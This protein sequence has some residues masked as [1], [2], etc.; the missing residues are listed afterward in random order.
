[1]AERRRHAAVMP[2]RIPNTVESTV[3]TP[4]SATVAPALLQISSITGAFV[5]YERP[6]LRVAVCLMYAQNWSSVEPSR[7]NS[8]RS[9]AFCAS[10]RLRPRNSVP[11]GSLERT[12]NRK[13]LNTTTK[14]RVASDPSPCLSTNRR[15]HSRSSAVR[16]RMTSH[17]TP[18]TAIKAITMPTIR[19]VL[20]PPS[21]PPPPLVAALDDDAVGTFSVA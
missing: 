8:R 12:R 21:S 16:R 2:I 9:S 10:L 6:R 18:P 5:A 20:P 13:K 15:C 19:P 4:T 11:T 1:M 7:P 17:T 14:A 3:E